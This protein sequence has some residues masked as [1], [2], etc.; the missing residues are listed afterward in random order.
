MV[1][2]EAM[3]I[4]FTTSKPFAVKVYVRG[5][6]AVSGEAKVVTEEMK[7]RRRE[8]CWFIR[9]FLTGE[10]AVDAVSGTDIDIRR[11]ICC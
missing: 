9:D 10:I 7:G 4:N 5:V 1:E 11:W 2:R 8:V 3:W 6:N